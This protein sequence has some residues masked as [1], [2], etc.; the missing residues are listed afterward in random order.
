MEFLDLYSESRQKSGKIIQR[1]QKVPKGSYRLV[2]HVCVFDPNGKM[3]IQKRS[4]SKKLWPGM[5]DVS[6]AGGVKHGENARQ[7]AIRECQE[8][9]GADLNDLIKGQP[10]FSLSFSEG[11]DDFFL[12]TLAGRPE[13]LAAQK[14]EVD[15]L[16]WASKEEIMEMIQSSTFIPYQFS[17]IDL[18]FALN[19]D[20]SI[21]QLNS[22][23][24]EFENSES[25]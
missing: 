16:C 9:I 11:F 1:S 5:W 19:K 14:S 10:D 7:A 20:H 23:S 8:E 4:Q 24:C 25:V 17:L 22:Q 3:L 21:Y 13:S 12:V 6:V 15:S 18:I 2:I